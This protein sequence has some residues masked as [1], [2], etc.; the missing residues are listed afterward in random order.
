MKRWIA[1]LGIMVL[2]LCL[3]LERTDVA[4]LH[5]VQ[6]VALYK[7]DTGYRV[8]TDTN[9]SGDGTSVDAAYRDLLET[10]PGIIYLDTADFLLVSHD[11]LDKIPEIGQ[12]LKNSVRICEVQGCGQLE[13][14]SAFL[15]VQTGLPPIS[16]WRTD[17]KLPILDCTQERI[18]FL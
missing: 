6:T 13:Q 5:P 11:A 2:V 8:E 15:S 18:K 4:D 14:V 3:P 1:Y 17:R 9:D 10:T 16:K 7:T 12:Y